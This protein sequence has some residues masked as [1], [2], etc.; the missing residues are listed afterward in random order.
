M[1]NTRAKY[2]QSDVQT[3]HPTFE[4]DNRDQRGWGYWCSLWL[5]Q[6]RRVSEPGA[7]ICVFT[8]WRQLPTATD[9]V[10]AGG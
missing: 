2:Q 7:A 3:E 6:C 9:I 5:G 10:Q 1:V 4:G 8:D